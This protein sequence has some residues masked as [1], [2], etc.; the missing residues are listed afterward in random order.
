MSQ[1]MFS[2]LK[3]AAAFA[4]VHLST[5]LCAK[6]FFGDRRGGIEVQG[7][8]K[9]GPSSKTHDLLG[10]NVTTVLYQAF[11]AYVGTL[12]WFDGSAAAIG[13]TAQNRLYGYSAPSHVLVVA[14]WTFELY[15][16]IAVII[17][18]EYCNAAF[19]AHHFT[20]GVLG[21]LALHPFVHYCAPLVHFVCPRGLRLPT[22]AVGCRA[23]GLL[24]AG[25]GLRAAGC[26]LRASRCAAGGP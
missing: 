1:L 10:Y 7:G 22:W 16:T 19:I 9:G 18:P 6:A 15:N 13:D 2:D 21:V 17:M 25:C 4:L 5:S 26:G 3:W 8:T 12:A 20:T 23:V 11:V 24:A 14:T